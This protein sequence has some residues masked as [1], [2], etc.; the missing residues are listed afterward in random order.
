MN[1]YF[2]YVISDFFQ[3]IAKIWLASLPPSIGSS[4]SWLPTTRNLQTPGVRDL[5]LAWPPTLKSK[6]TKKPSFKASGNKVIGPLVFRVVEKYPRLALNTMH[7]MKIFWSWW[8]FSCT[9]HWDRRIC[10]RFSSFTFCGMLSDPKRRKRDE[11]RNINVLG[12]GEAGGTSTDTQSPGTSQDK[13][14]Q[15]IQANIE[16]DSSTKRLSTLVNM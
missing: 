11:N 2:L 13:R 5:R 15:A 14:R 16:E 4:T 3:S 8:V 6:W 1:Q 7:T 12:K 10:P 9:F